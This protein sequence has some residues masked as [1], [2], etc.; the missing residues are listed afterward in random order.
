M[1]NFFFNALILSRFSNL[2]TVWTNV[3]V[4]W[5]INSSASQT[6][7]IIPEIS[8]F[9]FFNGSTF[10]FLILGSSLIY[11]GGCT[12]ND[13]FDENF[14]K[15][16]NP[17]RPLPSG[18]ISIKQVWLLGGIEI[19]LG[20]FFLINLAGCD[21]TWVALLVFVVILYDIVHK[22]WTGGIVLMGLCRLFLWL[23][24]ATCMENS[25]IA[26]QTLIWGI[27]L[28]CFIIGISS[29][30]RSESKNEFIQ[31]RFSILLLFS[32]SLITLAG[33]VYW[34]N[35][36]PIRVF[37][38]NIV[39]LLAAWIVFSSVL[40]TRE[41]KKG[42]IGNGV[43]RLLSGICAID[44]T[45][46]AFYSPTLIAPVLCCLSFAVLLQKKFAAT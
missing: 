36:D 28:M 42:C 37:L 39:G 9:E 27:V 17:Q 25:Q 18:S 46:I 38:I 40:I 2:P 8:T 15:R 30:A 5:T 16:N 14:D 44:A 32:S 19:S 11:A 20:T 3:L 41:R 13:A 12:L 6:L 10:L 43:S 35:L 26:P 1:K 4:A 31:S 24:A 34:N 23:S 45:A 21:L 29:F 22:K 7:K 33:L